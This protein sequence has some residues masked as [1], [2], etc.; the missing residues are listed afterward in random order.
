MFSKREFG[1][2]Q[3][4]MASGFKETMDPAVAQSAL[5]RAYEQANGDHGAASRHGKQTG[6]V[7]FIFDQRHF[8]FGL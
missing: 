1:S 3:G 2:R 6:T 4:R 5:L 8:L 7:T